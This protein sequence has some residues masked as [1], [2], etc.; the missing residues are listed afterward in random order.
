MYTLSRTS[1]STILRSLLKIHFVFWSPTRAFPW[2]IHI[3]SFYKWPSEVI[4][5]DSPHPC[6]WYQDF[7]HHHESRPKRLLKRFKKV[8]TFSILNQLS[9]VWRIFKFSW[10]H[11]W[12]LKL[13]CLASAVESKKNARLQNI[14]VAWLCLR[15]AIYFAMVQQILKYGSAVWSPNQKYLISSWWGD[16]Y[17][18]MSFYSKMFWVRFAANPMTA[19]NAWKERKPYF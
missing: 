4:W 16:R 7:C 1:W 12:I 8:W 11:H 19:T 14:L 5:K 3:S 6:R 13:M 10:H 2:T 9:K 18:S 17:G 15:I